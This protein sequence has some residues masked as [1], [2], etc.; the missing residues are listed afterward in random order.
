M[1]AYHREMLG[2]LAALGGVRG[3]ALSN[4]FPFASAERVALV[5]IR[6]EQGRGSPDGNALMETASPG[7]F[8][9]L[10]IGLLKGRT[11]SW[12]DGRDHPRVAI[13][14]ASLARLLF[15]EGKAIGQRIRIGPSPQAPLIEI[16]G[17]VRDASPGDLRLSG[18]PMVYRPIVQEPADLQNPVIVL[19]TA[20]MPALAQNI[21]Q[22]VESPGYAYVV[23]IK[24]VDEQIELTLATERTLVLLSSFV[25]G[26]GLLL[27]GIGVYALLSYNLSRRLREMGLRLALGASARELEAMILR[28]G[29]T[30]TAIGVVL[31]TPLA[32][33][34][35]RV[36]RSLLNELPPASPVVL[37]GAAG[38]LL[39]VGILAAL[40]PARRASGIDP[41]T[42]LRAE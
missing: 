42:G 6:V 7:F 41:A 4:H 18:L 22:T 5:P 9:L 35:S 26:L 11:F 33:G 25:G 12:D 8:E 29:L 17:V 40:A 20:N 10:G 37:A 34:T 16:V 21:R 31:G 38:V 2:Q 28:Q 3:A 14:N 13:V 15:G 19:R 24:T 30:L 27:A 32:L 23:S 39:I 36:A 1:E